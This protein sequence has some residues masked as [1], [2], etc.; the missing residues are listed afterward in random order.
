MSQPI[1]FHFK[2]REYKLKGDWFFSKHFYGSIRF[3]DNRDGDY[4]RLECSN[5]KKTINKFSGEYYLKESLSEDE[6]HKS[7]RAVR[8]INGSEVAFTLKLDFQQKLLS[9]ERSGFGNII[10]KSF[11]P[12]GI[13]AFFEMDEKGWYYRLF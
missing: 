12:G 2:I 6:Q 9:I 11:T 1:L 4:F 7:Y 10:L 8:E 5:R 3:Y 13:G